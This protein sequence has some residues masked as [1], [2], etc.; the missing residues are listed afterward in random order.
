MLSKA[1]F[2]SKDFKSRTHNRY[3]WFRFSG[4][5]YVPTIFALLT[6]AEW[7]FL[8]QWYADSELKYPGPGECSVP[9]MSMLLGLITGNNVSRIVQLGHYIGFSTILLGFIL[10]RMGHN[11]AL[12]SV[13]IDSKATE[14]TQSWLDM[15]GINDQ[16]RLVVS[17][18]ADSTLPSKAINYLGGS[19]QLIFIDSSHQYKHTIQELD[20][21]YEHLTPGGFIILHDV[22]P[23]AAQYDSTKQGGVI[24]AANEWLKGRNVS[25]SL[26]NSFC[27]GTQSID[28]LIY[29]DGCGL[30]IIQKPG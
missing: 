17:D 10:R 23:F 26:I 9:A 3:W 16:V 8:E 11:W 20:L 25:A 19:P 6:D 21:W 30:G 27:D 28:S 15:A 13:D 4:A 18:S 2:R 7:D 29:R 12:F 1:N 5:D 14:Y 24:T 22:S